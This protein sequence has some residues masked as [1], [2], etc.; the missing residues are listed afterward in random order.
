V[1]PD[2]MMWYSRLLGILKSGFKK[3]FKL[4][5]GIDNYFHYVNTW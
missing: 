5:L 4:G 1:K 2:A 3:L